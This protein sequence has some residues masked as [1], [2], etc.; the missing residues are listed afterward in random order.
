MVLL[1]DIIEVFDLA[2]LDFGVVLG[3]VALDRRDVGAALVDG[4][5]LGNTMPASS[6]V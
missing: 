5:L 3:I 4:D 6:L 2:E 1:D